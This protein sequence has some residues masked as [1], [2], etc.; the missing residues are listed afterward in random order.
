VSKARYTNRTPKTY[1]KDSQFFNE[2]KLFWRYIKYHKKDQTGI[3]S[4]QTSD[5]VATTATEKAEVL[6][7]TVKSVSTTEDLGPQPALPESTYPTL[8]EIGIT[9]QGVFALLSHIDPHKACGPDK[10]SA[11]VLH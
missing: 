7:N 4:L 6:N 10:I 3:G 2:N 8:P 9:E 5:G 11:K 1:C